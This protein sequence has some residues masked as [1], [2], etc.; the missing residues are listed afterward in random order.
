MSEGMN[1]FR[2]H[3]KKQSKWF[4]IG[5][6][7]LLGAMIMFS[8]AG[9]ADMMME[10]LAEV[11]ME[12]VVLTLFVIISAV[13]ILMEGIYKASGLLFNCRDDDLMLSLP[14]KKTTVLAVRVLKFYLFE[15]M[16]NAL[17]L[18]FIVFIFISSR[19]TLLQTLHLGMCL[20]VLY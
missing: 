7:I 16:I 5:L 8:V 9:Y 1:V 19:I 2:L 6:P 12:F 17:I 4:K 20:S 15:T 10:P 11:E 14:V 3:G 13:F 18:A